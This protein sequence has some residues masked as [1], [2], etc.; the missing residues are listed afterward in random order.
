MTETIATIYFLGLALFSDRVPDHPGVHALLPHIKE[1]AAV[2]GHRHVEP[3]IAGIIFAKSDLKETIGCTLEE[4]PEH[5]IATSDTAPAEPHLMLPLDGEQV[6]F[7]TGGENYSVNYRGG[8]FPLPK[9]ECV[10]RFENNPQYA[11]MVSVPR[12]SLASCSAPRNRYDTQLELHNPGRLEIWISKP[13][14]PTKVVI[15]EGDATV[16]VVNVPKIDHSTTEVESEAHF[17]AYYEMVKP[18]APDCFKTL[19]APRPVDRCPQIALTLPT[20]PEMIGAVNSECSNST[21]P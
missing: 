15:L 14:S 20:N 7:F 3:H 12:G 6:S 21:W 8:E 19:T 16:Y 2:A 9:L 5:L 13:R 4:A 17:L 10:D 11:A 1:R 18:T